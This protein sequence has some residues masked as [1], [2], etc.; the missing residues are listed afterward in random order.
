MWVDVEFDRDL[1][2]FVAKTEDG[3]EWLLR[4]RSWQGAVVEAEM[5]VDGR[6][7]LMDEA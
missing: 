4:S 2:G 7:L 3:R 6:E 1:G 5:Q